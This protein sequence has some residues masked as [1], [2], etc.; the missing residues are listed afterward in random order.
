MSERKLFFWKQSISGR[1]PVEFGELPYLIAS[2]MH[3]GEDARWL[4]AHTIESELRAQ[5]DAGTLRVRNP[6]SLGWH[7]FPLGAQLRS[8]VLMP[9]EVVPLF[10]ERGIELQLVDGDE[11]GQVEESNSFA[12]VHGVAKDAARREFPEFDEFG[13]PTGEV[14]DRQ[15]LDA[16]QAFHRQLLAAV[17]AGALRTLGPPEFSAEAQPGDAVLS[18]AGREAALEIFGQL[19]RCSDA[20]HTSTSLASRASQQVAAAA[21]AARHAAGFYY[22]TEAAQALADAQGID[23][24]RMRDDLE[25]A[26]NTGLLVFRDSGSE[27]PITTRPV[28]VFL[29]W[30]HI[31]D[32]DA[33]LSTWRVSYRFPRAL[34]DPQPPQCAVSEEVV[35]AAKES[36]EQRC[37]RILILFEAEERIGKRGA[38]ARVAAKDGRTRQT[39]SED[40]KKAKKARQSNA[41]IGAMTRIFTSK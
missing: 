23:A 28:R 35:V 13:N 12:T 16:E 3:T 20:G 38:L 6:V 25:R 2:A 21:K 8:A 30:V 26:A 7:T 33:L 34:S 19:V 15:R 22:L 5:V 39:I 29:D 14:G 11:T 18:P 9:S 10:A 31:E 41:A 1:L 4:A 36:S 32:I 24:R 40:L 37:A 27:V 17:E